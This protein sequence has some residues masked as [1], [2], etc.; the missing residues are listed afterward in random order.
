MFPGP[1]ASIG[2]GLKEAGILFKRYFGTFRVGWL[3]TN[4]FGEAG[5]DAAK[6]AE[7]LKNEVGRFYCLKSTPKT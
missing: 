3:V 6:Q 1:T 5:K 4:K 2:N 7:W